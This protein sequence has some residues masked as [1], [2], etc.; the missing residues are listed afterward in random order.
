LGELQQ[1]TLDRQY[2][3]NVDSAALL[4]AGWSKVLVIKDLAQLMDG[5]VPVS[6]TRLWQV[7]DEDHVHLG[8]NVGAKDRIIAA[9]TDVRKDTHEVLKSLD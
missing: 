7:W 2:G 8:T 1:I 3:A 5:S 9:L 4:R 6:A